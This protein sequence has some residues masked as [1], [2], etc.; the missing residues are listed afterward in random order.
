MSPGLAAE[1]VTARR[2]ALA[3]PPSFH[4]GG[5]D[6]EGENREHHDERQGCI[7]L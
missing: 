6:A 4:D 1:S 7:D 3:A 2:H 5:H